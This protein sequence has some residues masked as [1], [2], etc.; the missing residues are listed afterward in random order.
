MSTGVPQ[1]SVLGPLLFSFYMQPIENIIKKH[2]LRFH[3]Y[4]DDLQIYANF[5]YNSQSIYVCL[6]RLRICVMD[7][8]EWFKTNTLVINDDKTEY[9]PFIPKQHDAL[10]AT[11]SIRVG[12]DSIPASKSVTN[13]VVVLDKHYIISH[14]VSKIIHSY[15]YKLPP[16]RK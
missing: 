12:V 6:E 9:I 2:G 14:Q 1:G 7:I 8:Q 16:I 4:A 3:Q 13:L 15:T 11:S 5:E 10:L